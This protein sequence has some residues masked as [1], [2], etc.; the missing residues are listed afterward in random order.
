MLNRSRGFII[1]NTDNMK[2]KKKDVPSKG[3]FSGVGWDVCEDLRNYTKVSKSE[4]M[5][6]G[7]LLVSRFDCNLPDRR[8]YKLPA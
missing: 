3:T 8:V 2:K 7:Q 5:I 1:N 6:D 4:L